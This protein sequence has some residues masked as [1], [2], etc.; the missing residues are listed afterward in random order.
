VWWVEV[1]VRSINCSEHTYIQRRGEDVIGYIY[2]Y[3]IFERV[4]RDQ[5]STETFRREV[6]GF[7]T[8][9]RAYN[10]TFLNHKYIYIYIY[11]A[12]VI[13]FGQSTTRRSSCLNN[14]INNNTYVKSVELCVVGLWLYNNTSSRSAHC[15]RNGLIFSCPRHAT[16]NA[17]ISALETQMLYLYIILYARENYFA[18]RL[19]IPTVFDRSH[20]PLSSVAMSLNQLTLSLSICN[21]GLS[22]R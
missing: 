18:Q 17:S 9:A 7:L 15:P 21:F 19:P 4:K 2:I 5:R 1:G 16:G 20:I 3:I 8:G 14:N 11:T 13:S 12:C 22:V 10:I 6:S